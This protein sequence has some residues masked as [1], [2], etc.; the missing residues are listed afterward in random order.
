MQRTRE[1]VD[2]ERATATLEW[3]GVAAAIAVLLT[4]LGS[5]V[6]DEGGTLGRAVGARLEAATTGEPRRWRAAREA[7]RGG[8]TVPV[9]VSRDELRMSPFIDE[10]AVAAGSRGW[11]GERGGVRGRLTA[12]GC[13]LCASAEWSHGIGPSAGI[14]SEGRHAGLSA[15]VDVAARVALASAEVDGSLERGLGE[16]GRAF[17]QGRL[18]GTLGAEGDAAA[19]VQLGGS[20]IDAQV[21]AGAMVGAVA[22]AE[23]RAGLD[24]VGISIRQSARAEGWA[25]AGIRGTAGVR[26][27]PGVTSWRLGWGGALGIGGASE[28]SGTVDASALPERHR[29]LGA[30]T[31]A[32]LLRT[33]F[34]LSAIPPIPHVIEEP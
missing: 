11:S 25:G 19:Q 7:R 34:G 15:G 1:A 14:G 29:R 32:A 31:L 27:S 22:R 20:T 23:A 26:R 30:G 10:R 24:L 12:R 21:D 33:T 28:W 4:A 9:R 18:R 8:G 2:G 6:G 17:A 16:A 3:A 5:A 13:L